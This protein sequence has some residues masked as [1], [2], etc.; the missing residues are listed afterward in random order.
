MSG[1]Y[2]R[3]I[4]AVCVGLA[5]T[6]GTACDRHVNY[7]SQVDPCQQ[8]RTAQGAKICESLSN[9]LARVDGANKTKSYV[10]FRSYCDGIEERTAVATPA[11]A[12]ANGVTKALAQA[13][14]SRF[15]LE[16]PTEGCTYAAELLTPRGDVDPWSAVDAFD[17]YGPTR[18]GLL[19]LGEP[20]EAVTPLDFTGMRPGESVE[21]ISL[22]PHVYRR[23]ARDSNYMGED[24]PVQVH[25]VRGFVLRD[26]DVSEFR[27]H[28]KR[29]SKVDEHTLTE[30]VHRAAK[31]FETM[32]DTDKGRFY[33]EYDPYRD[34][35]VDEEYNLLRHAGSSWSIM[36]AYGL[37]GDEKLRELGEYALDW[38]V[39]H[40]RTEEKQGRTIRFVVEPWNNKAK[41]GGAGLWLLA[42]AEHARLTG[43]TSN[44]ELMQQVANYIYLSQDPKTGKFASFHSNGEVFAPDFDSD[45]YPGEAMFAL[46]RARPFLE[47]IPVCEVTQKGLEFMLDDE[48]RQLPKRKYRFVNQWNAYSIREY[49]RDCNDKQ[50]DWVWHRDLDHML[51]TSATLDDDPVVAGAYEQ[52]DG[53]FSISPTRLEA[54]TTICAELGSEDD[55]IARR[56]APVIRRTA[57]LQLSFQHRSS[58]TWPWRN[59][60]AANGGF[61]R[62]LDDESIRIDFTQHHLSAMYNAIDFLRHVGGHK[63]D[64][65][66]YELADTARSFPFNLVGDATCGVSDGVKCL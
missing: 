56:C 2:V 60:K 53:D 63:N 31:W 28:R 14:E 11:K 29:H 26:G 46:H 19:I 1:G 23:T 32:R 13:V 48:P 33:Y 20:R 9:R 44:I 17:S 3:G 37:T 50:F 64:E 18:D 45:Y 21:A 57:A 22:L 38:I 6:A 24:T 16:E 10:V 15:S 39:G 62:G 55:K 47:D 49:R 52:K 36:Q 54:L 40:S 41:L 30:G 66:T 42:L 59:P 7:Q 43:D 8:L 27:Y 25:D 4:A 58:N 5:I 12:G 34:V 65:G 61:G 35:H 51:A